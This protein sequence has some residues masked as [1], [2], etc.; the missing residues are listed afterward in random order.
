MARKKAV[1][2]QLLPHVLLEA[3]VRLELV[4][5]DGE[6]CHKLTPLKPENPQTYFNFTPKG[7]LASMLVGNLQGYVRGSSHPLH[8]VVVAASGLFVPKDCDI[9]HEDHNHHN[10]HISNLKVVNRMRHI[11]YHATPGNERFPND[12]QLSLF[13]PRN[14]LRAY[15]KVTFPAPPSTPPGVCAGGGQAGQASSGSLEGR[16]A[17]LNPHRLG[18]VGVSGLE[19]V[20]DGAGDPFGLPEHRRRTWKARELQRLG[21]P[22]ET[23]NAAGRTLRAVRKLGSNARAVPIVA[24]VTAKGASE[25]TAYRALYWLVSEGLIE[26][27]D[28]RFYRLTEAAWTVEETRRPMKQS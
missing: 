4:F 28:S 15:V 6:D 24:L 26:K 18:D 11:Q 21:L 7:R 27:H 1:R 5:E 17:S 16:T 2:A 20:F 23:A 9:H 12:P 19:S 13:T 22:R 14:G 3:P 8:R 10:N 25:R